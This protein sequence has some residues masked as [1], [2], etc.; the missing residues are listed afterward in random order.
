MANNTKAKQKCLLTFIELPVTFRTPVLGSDS[1]CKG[2]WRQVSSLFSCVWMGH[3]VN[4]KTSE[5]L[6]PCWIDRQLQ[7]NPGPEGGRSFLNATIEV[8]HNSRGMHKSINWVVT[9]ALE[10]YLGLEVMRGRVSRFMEGSFITR[11]HSK[12]WGSMLRITWGYYFEFQL[13]SRRC[14]SKH[15]HFRNT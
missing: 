2:R 7:M 9:A 14:K 13:Y 11:I 3:W 10:R 6:D 12:W 1:A 8:Q 5:C 4:I 15:I